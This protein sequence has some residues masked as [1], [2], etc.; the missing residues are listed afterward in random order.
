MTCGGALTLNGSGS[1][2]PDGD[3]LTYSWTINGQVNAATGA[4][5]TLSWSQ[6]QALG[7]SSVQPFSV[8][9]QVNDGV[10]TTS[11][12]HNVTVLKAPLT[13]TA[14]NASKFYGSVN[15]AFTASYAGFVNGDTAGDLG[16]TLAFST[17]ATISSP[18][19]SYPV[20]PSGPA[21]SL[22]YNITFVPGTLT[23]TLVPSS[24][25]VLN[26][27]STSGA[28]TISGNATIN[29]PG[30][31]VVDSTSSAILA[32]G[33]AKITAAAGVQVVGGVSKSGNASVTKTGT[34]GATGDPLASLAAPTPPSYTS[35]PTAETLSGNSTATISQGL[36]SQITVS[37]N[38]KLSL[39]PGVYVIGTGGVNISGN[40]TL[41]GSGVTYIV[42]G[43]GFTVSGNAGMSGSNVLIVNGG[44]NYPNP[45]ISGETY[46]GVTLS[47]NGSFSLNAATSGT[48]A[49]ILIYQA[50]DNTRAVSVSGN[51][52]A[53]ITGTIYAA[54]ALLTMSGN[55]SLQNPLVVGTL[56]LSG[57]VALT[58][59]AQGSDGAG[60][61]AGIADTLLAG[62]LDIYI[63]DP[64]GYFTTDMLKRAFR[65]P[66]M[67]STPCS[68][69]LTSRS[70]RSATPQWPTSSWIMG[71]PAPVG[72]WPPACSAVST[73]PAAR[74]K[75]P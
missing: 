23:V 21:T 6:L 31:L 20:T 41:S 62:S 17:P 50:R 46:G 45:A 47:G 33:N 71:P 42:E 36:Y 68:P 2:D 58:Q 70:R 72:T 15:P 75:S 34:P 66:S 35:A 7:I 18:L 51:S 3:P 19:G 39:N 73:Q 38:A 8:S 28:L 63:D 14:N 65:M 53:G 26:A 52:M 54:N 55:A 4:T 56:N 16:G 44:S 40:A 67:V 29:L 49:G 10:F 32:S 24:V 11:Q 5:P 61:S 12:A 1:Y 22:N 60:D 48:Y 37:G 43:G 13:V 9:V 30:A 64:S 57:N 74:L 25:Y 59:L 69:P 27:Q